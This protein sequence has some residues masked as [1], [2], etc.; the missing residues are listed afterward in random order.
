MIYKLF[1]SNR[2][3]VMA[4]L[5][6]PAVAAGALGYA[7]CVPGQSILA[8]PLYD[9]VFVPLNNWPWLAV[10]CTTLAVMSGALVLNILFNRHEYAVRESFLP[11]LLY[12]GFFA[13]NPCNFQLNPFPFANLLVIIGLWRL[14]GVYRQTSPTY[15]LYD[16]GIFFGLALLVYPLYVIF[17]PVIWIGLFTLRPFS[18]REWLLPLSGLL[19]PLS[20]AAVA[21][22]WFGYE[23][24]LQEYFRV[25][26]S[27][28]PHFRN[29]AK[30]GL[31][32]ALS[33]G[34]CAVG[35]GR[36]VLDMGVSTVHRKNSKAVWMWFTLC[37]IVIYFYGLSLAAYESRMHLVLVPL[38]SVFV[39]AFLTGKGRSIVL[40][41]FFYILLA[42]VLWQIWQNSATNF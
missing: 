33:A 7:F 32:V 1:A 6:I 18:L 26:W 27:F 13:A 31:L 28:S 12:I 39:G 4:L 30:S 22:W 11:S 34:L 23:V 29:L 5:L 2:Q 9:V 19:T 40:T 20:Y 15:K 14:L 41:A 21:Y 3:G 42:L 8:G 17:L 10:C 38:S 16:T 36:F 37:T 35:A 25:D 24:E